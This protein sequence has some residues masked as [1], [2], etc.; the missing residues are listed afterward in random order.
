M[1]AAHLRT[2]EQFGV[3]LAT[4]QALRHRVADLAVAVEAA[5]ST[6][7]YAMRLAAARDPELHV[8]APMAKLVATEA[9]YRVAAESIQLHGGIGFTWEHDAHLY[10]KRATVNRLLHGD[11]L[12]LRRTVGQRAGI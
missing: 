1:A 8:V 2:R 7:W 5:T 10:L 9:A 4:F 6:A 11:P 12:T 3:P